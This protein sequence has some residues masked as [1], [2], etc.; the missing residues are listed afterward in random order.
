M[1]ISNASNLA[2]LVAAT[3]LTLSSMA[4]ADD[5]NAGKDAGK[6]AQNSNDASMSNDKGCSASSNTDANG[7][8]TTETE[9]K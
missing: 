9:A 1:Q 4:Y 7:N 3:V 8:C 2:A 5:K 6:N